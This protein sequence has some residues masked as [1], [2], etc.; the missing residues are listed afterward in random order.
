MLANFS[1]VRKKD[2]E[3]R[4]KKF[5]PVQQYFDK[6]RAQLD[7]WEKLHKQRE[8]QRL[9]ELERQKQQ[10]AEAALAKPA[11]KNAKLNKNQSKSS[12]VTIN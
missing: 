4:S 8:L 11:P 1:Q 5:T 10:A 3:A 2:M 9:R 12:K 7:D 6:S